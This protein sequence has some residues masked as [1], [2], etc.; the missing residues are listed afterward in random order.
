MEG[1]VKP[2]SSSYVVYLLLFIS[3]IV[4]VVFGFNNANSTDN[5]LSINQVADE[6]K[7]GNVESITEEENKL[8]IK[9]TS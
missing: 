9:L 6:I 1:L 7:K 2:R 4:L 8:T 3:I 5:T